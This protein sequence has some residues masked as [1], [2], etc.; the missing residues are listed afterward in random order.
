MRIISKWKDYYDGGAMYGIDKTRIYIRKTECLD[1]PKFKNLRFRYYEIIGFCGEIYIFKN[2]VEELDITDNAYSKSKYILWNKDVFNY[3]YKKI[4]KFGI[5]SIL[6]KIEEK[7]WLGED[8][9]NKTKNSK[10]L[11]N[12]FLKYKVP[13]F[14]VEH[15][16]EYH[17]DKLILNPNLKELGFT[18]FYN[19]TQ[20]FQRIE[21]F[22][23]N[24][25]ASE[26]Q[27]NIP[28]GGNEVL[29]RSKGFDKYSFRHPDTKK[30]PKRF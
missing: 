9:Y 29:G 25:L 17:R 10:E 21:Q 20:A 1:V 30:K 22:I 16:S 19:T 23:S 6:K 7:N 26:F 3:T 4:V 12:L 14:Y 8:H 2:F 13:I 24:E 27:P 18:K 28:T 15:S 11:N 5:A